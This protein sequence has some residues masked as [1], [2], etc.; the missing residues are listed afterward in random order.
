MLRDSIHVHGV[1]NVTSKAPI[2]E[3]QGALEERIGIAQIM[4]FVSEWFL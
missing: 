4:G 1:H 3:V 2:L